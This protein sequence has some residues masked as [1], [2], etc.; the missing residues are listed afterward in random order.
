MDKNSVFSVRSRGKGDEMGSAAAAKRAV[1]PAIRQALNPGDL[2]A[3]AFAGLG[4]DNPLKKMPAADRELV[5]ASLVIFAREKDNPRTSLK[6]QKLEALA[7]AVSDAARLSAEIKELLRNEYGDV[8]NRRLKACQGLPAQLDS[9]M[10]QVGG[11]LYTTGFKKQRAMKDY[12]LIYA[13]ELVRLRTGTWNDEPLAELL[14]TLRDEGADFSGD[15]IHK[16]RE[17]FK[18]KY[19]VV[20]KAIVQSVAK[21]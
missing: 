9:F 21:G 3:K 8:L 6:I 10:T 19:P 12:R 15:A 13:S 16:K 2:V 20:Y 11:L 5:W 7:R 4:G 1:A 17:R 14:Q 18:T